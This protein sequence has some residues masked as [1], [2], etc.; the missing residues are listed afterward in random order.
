MKMSES[1]KTNLRIIVFII[2]GGLI[3]SEF[4]TFALLEKISTF[5]TFSISYLFITGILLGYLTAFVV[6]DLRKSFFISIG[7]VIISFFLTVL[8]YSVPSLMGINPSLE[9]V[10]FSAVGWSMVYSLLLL[11]IMFFGLVIG[12]ILHSTK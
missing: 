10:V 9:P 4:T 1:T 3:L 2:L 8:F 12:F 6:K 11:M 7:L 5:P